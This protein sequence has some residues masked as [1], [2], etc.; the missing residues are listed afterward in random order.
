MKKYVHV[1]VYG[2]ISGVCV[3][4]LDHCVKKNAFSCWLVSIQLW[5][6]LEWP[7]TELYYLAL[8]WVINH[9]KDMKHTS[10]LEHRVRNDH[11]LSSPVLT[12][13][14]RWLSTAPGNQES[15]KDDADC[16]LQ[17]KA[18]QTIAPDC[19]FVHIFDGS[20]IH[21]VWESWNHQYFFQKSQ[22]END[23]ESHS[24]TKGTFPVLCDACNTISE[25]SA[26]FAGGCILGF[27]RKSSIKR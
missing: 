27:C 1:S 23:I 26:L 11:R 6:E 8:C 19:I 3:Y 12:S 16:V 24:P 14:H 17:K 2:V 21:T 9:S 4:K 5:L 13:V 10:C 25:Q 22:F 15:W 18:L 20:N 7:F